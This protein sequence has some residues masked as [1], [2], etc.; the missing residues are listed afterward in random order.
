M[1]KLESVLVQRRLEADVPK[2][3]AQE[4][5]RRHAG[6]VRQHDAPAGRG[7]L[8]EAHD[9][10]SASVQHEREE[11]GREIVRLRDPSREVGL[12]GGE[13]CAAEARGAPAAGA[14]AAGHDV[15]R[16]GS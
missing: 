6:A 2:V 10:A 9:R 11:A 16:R 5:A 1:R 12:R 3:Q 14:G 7:V 8:L 4:G 13:E 15:G